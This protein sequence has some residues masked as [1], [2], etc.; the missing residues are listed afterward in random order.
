MEKRLVDLEIRYTHLERQLEE[1]NAVLFAQQRA[2]DAL[3]K[4]VV[5]LRGRIGDM[6]DEAFDERPPH[7]CRVTRAI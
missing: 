7:Y 3:E 5:A 1:M 4:Q 6:G 2:I